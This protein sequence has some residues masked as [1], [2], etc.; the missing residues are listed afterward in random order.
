M[1]ICY[2]FWGVLLALTL[3]L[4]SGCSNLALRDAQSAYQQGD[5]ATA[6]VKIDLYSEKNIEGRNAIIAQLEKGS[7]YRALE[8]YEQSNAAF[9]I[10]NQQFEYWDM[11]PEFKIGDESA[12]MLTNLNMLPYRGYNYD[13]IMLYTYRALNYMQLGHVDKA[14]V[15]MKRALNAQREAVSRNAKRLEKMQEQ[16]EAKAQQERKKKS[17][18][19]NADKTLNSDKLKA[20]MG[21]QFA[22]LKKH[23]AYADYVNPFTEF[24]QG[25]YYMHA[26]LDGSDLDQ[27]RLSLQ[28]VRNMVPSN[29][30]LGQDLDA[31]LR[32]QA[33]SEREPITYVIYEA[34]LA[35]SR[36][37][38]RIDLPLFLVNDEVDY[39][40]M[41]FP[42]LRM[43]NNYIATIS[44]STPAGRI[45]TQPI[46]SMDSIIA[47]EFTNELP[48]IVTKTVL[49]SA[50]KAAAAW[51]AK[52]A[53]KKDDNVQFMVQLGTAIY[54]AATAEADLRTWATLPKEFQYARVATPADKT[55]KIGLG[56]GFFK[57]VKLDSGLINVV[58][59]KSI[60]LGHP[61]KVTQF[62][63]RK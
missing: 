50:T 48:I 26:S 32:L 52:N 10:A 56:E 38:V 7:I 28:R 19:F 60:T 58:Y 8:Q 22:E 45:A 62:V 44:I 36:D 2:T 55:I 17:G 35:P 41:A 34:G 31:I 63:L 43:H 1:R 51:A 53:T 39:V 5:L 57:E 40:A 30:Y 23:Q 3:S 27:A 6:Q 16:A 47:Q 18:G 61:P 59:V 37:D 14:R 11:Q 46:A 4:C 42:T 24:L 20:S 25:I 29:A 21:A 54:Q 33:G 49:N 12:A 9:E 15:E 13:R